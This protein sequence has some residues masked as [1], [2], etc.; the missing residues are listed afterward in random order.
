VKRAK[1]KSTLDIKVTDSGLSIEFDGPRQYLKQVK[2][3]LEILRKSGKIPF[4]FHIEDDSPKKSVQ[5]PGSSKARRSRA[6]RD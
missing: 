2:E 1:K 4:E 5:K 3:N 6:A